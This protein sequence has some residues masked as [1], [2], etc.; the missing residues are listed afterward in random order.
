MT[1]TVKLLENGFNRDPYF[2]ET[3]SL[4]KREAYLSLDFSDIKGQYMA[5]RAMEVAA[6]GGHNLIMVG[7]PGSGKTMLA[8]RLPSILPMLTLKEAI[9]ATKIYSISGSHKF[10][11]GLIRERPFRSPHHT[12][13]DIALIGGGRGI[14]NPGEVSLA[15]HGV[16]FLDE[17]PEFKKSVLEVL[18]QP[19]EDQHVTISRAAASLNFPA[20]FMLVAAMNPSPKGYDVDNDKNINVDHQEMARYLSRLSGPLLDRIDIHIEVPALPLDDLQKSEKSEASKVI[21]SRVEKARQIQVSR[22]RSL[23]QIHCNAAMGSR[24]ISSYCKLDESS[25]SLLRNAI[26]K[27][28]LSARAYDRILR[29]SRTIADLEEAENIKASHIAEAVQY[30]SLDKKFGL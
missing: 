27:F 11:H 17:L 26:E 6:T 15:H 18:R 2:I 29:V 25:S 3:E 7:P 20:Q 8:R 30:R 21:R 10:E 13:S 19:M 1:E 4:F 28:G 12:I 22:F 9:D 24:E 14:P 16:L 5:K 23:P